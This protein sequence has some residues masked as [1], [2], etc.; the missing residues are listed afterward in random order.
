MSDYCVVVVDNSRARFFTLEEPDVPE[1][2]SGP[3]LVERSDLTNPEAVMT[4]RETWSDVRSGRN[5]AR[6]GGPAHGYDDHRDSHDDEVNRRFARRVAERAHN[7][8]RRNRVKVLV[9]VAANRML[10]F[11]RETISV[12]NGRNIEIREAAKDLSRLSAHEIHRNLGNSRLLPAR[13]HRIPA[14]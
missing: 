2:E 12:P 4:G 7:F 11:L 10:G 14:T 9:L 6:G 1:I 8:A 13:N 5:T 3:N